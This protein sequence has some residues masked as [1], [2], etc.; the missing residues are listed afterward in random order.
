M[1][2]SAALLGIGGQTKEMLPQIKRHCSEIQNNIRSY[3]SCNFLIS[4]TELLLTRTKDFLP[5]MKSLPMIAR[6]EAFIDLTVAVEGC[7]DKKFNNKLEL[8]DWRLEK[9]FNP[10]IDGCKATGEG[11]IS[12]NSPRDARDEDSLRRCNF[13]CNDSVV[14]HGIKG[15]WERIPG[16]LTQVSKRNAGI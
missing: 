7:P 11:K 14:Q 9:G 3:H 13:A 4:F 10:T 2:T 16:G 15:S 8:Y 6:I 5:M 12:E 1:L